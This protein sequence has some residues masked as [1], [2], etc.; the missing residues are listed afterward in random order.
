MTFSADRSPAHTVNPLGFA[1]FLLLVLAALPVFWLGFQ[2]LAAAW[3]TPEYSHG[4]L[5]PL[6]SLYLFLRELRRD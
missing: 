5:I 6:I 1:W 3:I 4:P 2:S